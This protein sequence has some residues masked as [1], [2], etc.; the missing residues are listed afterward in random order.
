MPISDQAFTD[1]VERSAD[2]VIYMRQQYEAQIARLRRAL[3]LL[4]VP[5]QATKDPDKAP[6]LHVSVALAKR[7]MGVVNGSD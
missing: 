1:Y 6:P 3:D 4:G 5:A 7:A 2:D